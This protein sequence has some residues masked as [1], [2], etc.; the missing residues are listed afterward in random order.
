MAIAKNKY[1]IVCYCFIIILF[2]SMANNKSVALEYIKVDAAA[3]KLSGEIKI[4][5]ADIFQNYLAKMKIKKVILSSGGGNLISALSIGSLINSNDIET[6]VEENNTCASA[7]ALIWVAGVKRIVGKNS[8][9][10]FHAAYNKTENK[11]EISS[12]ANAL[13]G[14]Y[15]YKLGLPQQ[16]IIF[17]TEA[18]PTDMRWL[19]TKD[20]NRLGLE[21]YSETEVTHPDQEPIYISKSIWRQSILQNP[22]AQ[23]FAKEKPRDFDEFVESTYKIYIEK[24]NLKIIEYLIRSDLIKY[25][26]TKLQDAEDDILIQLAERKKRY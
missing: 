17:M 20:G 22:I 11:L 7:C 8:K 19:T 10:G 1:L 13:I 3:I 18:A 23:L 16:T 25:I 26:Y 21:F 14:V 15:L 5:D 4:E 6:V 24:D 12:S 9:I 2:Q